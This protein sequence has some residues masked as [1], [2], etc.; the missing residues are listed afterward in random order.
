MRYLAVPARPVPLTLVIAFALGLTFAVKAGFMGI[1]LALVLLSWTFKY[2]FVAF[3]AVSRGFD[4][5]PVLTIDMVNPA[6]EQRPLGMLLIVLVF[7]GATS[8]LSPAIGPTAT[9][10]LRL[11]ALAL[12]P[13]SLFTLAI[14]G[15]ILDAVNP[16]LLTQLIRRLGADYVVLIAVAVGLGALVDAFAS[17]VDWLIALIAVFL[18]GVLALFCVMG[19]I[20]YQRRHTLG[21]DAWQSP[22]RSA[23]R[24]ARETAR[25]LDRDLDELYQ[26]WRGG[27]QL[28]A[29]DALLAKLAAREHAFETYRIFHERLSRWPDT[30]LADRLAREFVERHGERAATLLAI[31]PRHRSAS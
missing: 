10:A 15:R 22:E 20:A 23:D 17:L 7:M 30:A 9:M 4:E 25:A 27:A 8:A 3:D 19:G 11:M 29:W 6:N 2:A 21:L 14:T 28:E 31:P 12:L 18:Y 24:E 1:W 16:L 26:H 5:P 13:A